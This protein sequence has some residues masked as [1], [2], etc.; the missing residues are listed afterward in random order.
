MGRSQATWYVHGT[1][2]SRTITQKQTLA[3]PQRM[4]TSY[5]V[6][7]LHTSKL[8]RHRP[9][10]ALGKLH[11]SA[12]PVGE[13]PQWADQRSASGIIVIGCCAA[14]EVREEP[15]A[16]V[17]DLCCARTQREKF[18]TCIKRFAA[19]QQPNQSSV[20]R[21]AKKT[22]VRIKSP[23]RADV[24]VTLKL[25]LPRLILFLSWQRSRLWSLFGNACRSWC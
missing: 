16:E 14:S 7:V 21:A 4:L 9:M 19:E 1:C 2:P 25:R 17:L 11:C 18:C 3:L 12:W 23:D 22:G 13:G 5:R 10:S 24:A 6:A 8:L 20:Q 15:I